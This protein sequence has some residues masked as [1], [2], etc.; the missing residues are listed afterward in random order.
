MHLAAQMQCTEKPRDVTRCIKVDRVATPLERRRQN[1]IRTT[2]DN[3]KSLERVN[4]E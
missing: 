3:L 2:G 4:E 1:D